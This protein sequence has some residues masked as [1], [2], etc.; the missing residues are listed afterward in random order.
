MVMKALVV[1]ESVLWMVYIVAM[2]IIL[3]LMLTH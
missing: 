2:G 1:R 3:A